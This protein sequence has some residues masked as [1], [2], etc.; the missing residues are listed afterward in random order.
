MPV[1]PINITKNWKDILKDKQARYTATIAMA[2]EYIALQ[3]LPTEHHPDMIIAGMPIYHVQREGH[4]ASDETLK[5]RS[6][7][8]IFLAHQKGG[9]R[10]FK[11]TLKVNGPVR[12]PVLGFLQ[13]LQRKGVQDNYSVGN[14]F[15]QIN[16]DVMSERD[17]KTFVPPGANS[18]VKYIQDYKGMEDETIA[19]HKTFPIITDT[20]IYTNMYL[21]TL[22]YTEDVKLGYETIEI[23]CAFREFIAPMHIR[24]HKPRKTGSMGYFSTWITDEERDALKRIDLFFNIFW[25]TKNIIEDTLLKQMENKEVDKFTIDGAVLAAGAF[26]SKAAWW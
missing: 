4:A 10:T 8:T 24:W 15:N 5:Y 9:K 16:I 7:G 1:S 11:C 23:D 13:Y 6:M 21:E 18:K 12:L 14:Y 22:R 2:L 3:L 17:P 20:K 19:Y 26:L 25:G